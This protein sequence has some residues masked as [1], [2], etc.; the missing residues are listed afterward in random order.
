MNRLRLSLVCAWLALAVTGTVFAQVPGLVSYQAR[1]VDDQSGPVNDTRTM[2]FSIYT[3]VTG[4]SAIWTE[5]QNVTIVDGLVN[6]LLGSVSPLT[7]EVFQ[8]SERYL[9]VKIGTDAELTPRKRLLAVPYALKAEAATIRLTPSGGISSTEVTAAI[10]EL[11]AEKL[12][13]AGGTLTGRLNVYNEGA[14]DVGLDALSADSVAVLAMNSGSSAPSMVSYNFGEGHA[15]YSFSEKGTCLWALGSSDDYATII[16]QSDGNSPALMATNSADLPTIYAVN[17][18]D[19]YAIHAEG[20]GDN[21]SVYSKAGNSNALVAINNSQLYPVMWVE[22]EGNSGAISALS[23]GSGAAIRAEANSNSALFAINESDYPTLHA[24]NSGGGSAFYGSALNSTGVSIRNTSN[25]YPTIY[26][27]SNGQASAIQG[28]SI[29]GTAGAF[30]SDASNYWTLFV[31]AA[32]GSQYSPGLKVNGYATITGGV[33]ATMLTSAGTARTHGVTSPQAEIDFSGT[34]QLTNGE[35]EISFP[36]TWQDCISGAGEYRV[37]ITPTEM[38]NGICCV[39]KTAGGFR[40]KELMGGAGSAS[41]DWMVR[42]VQKGSSTERTMLAG[43]QNEL[44]MEIIEETEEE[45][46]MLEVIPRQQALEQQMEEKRQALEQQS[47]ALS[48]IPEPEPR[49]LAPAA[50]ASDKME[51]RIQQVK[52]YKESLK[53]KA[54]RQ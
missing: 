8:G 53:R 36:Q 37:L 14:N 34:G 1:I 20:R 17:D 47:P 46:R 28:Y 30:Y 18:G 2:V 42:A 15:V 27:K 45:R 11:D 43:A 13:L 29:S 26:A 19:G 32:S 39:E 44:G 33:S 21:V 5:Q 23:N 16:A 51:Q 4:G 7:S 52:Q 3:Q 40:V 54:Q 35:A 24:S 9:G 12:G 50:A 48:A 22:A 49:P 38:C 25:D 6:V 41:F 31:N 10:S